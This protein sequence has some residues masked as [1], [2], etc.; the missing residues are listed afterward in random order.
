MNLKTLMVIKAVVTLIFGVGFVLIP[1]T[2]MSWYGL[3]LG[4]GGAYM[5]RLFGA[6]FIVICL[7]LWLGRK[8]AGSAAL[9]GLVIGV[10]IGDVIGFIVS[11]SVQIKGL[12][13]ALGW[14]TVILYLLLAIGF[15]YYAFR[16]PKAA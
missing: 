9:K 3:E 12:V 15:G 8:D 16:K 4:A 1:M 14:L 5:T 7:A 2:V 11:L 10:F 13:N 6:A